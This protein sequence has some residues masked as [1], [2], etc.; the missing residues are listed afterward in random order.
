LSYDPSFEYPKG[1]GQELLRQASLW[2]GALDSDGRPRVSGG[3]LLEFRPTL[4][5][6]DTIVELWRGRPGSRR[7]EDDGGGGRTDEEIFNG[8][9]DDGDGFIDE[10]LGIIGQQMLIA[11]YTDD[12]PEA[13]AYV[14]GPEPH[15]PLGLSV[16]QEAYAWS[17]PGYQGIAG[18][19]YTITNHSGRTLSGVYLGLFAHLDSRSRNALAGHLNDAIH[20]V[21]FNR[22]FPKGITQVFVELPEPLVYSCATRVSR[23]VPAV[24]EPRGSATPD[25]PVVAVL[26]L[27]H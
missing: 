8:R 14:S 11:D 9:D 21:G 6:S 7:G 17:A 23:D 25:L 13:V 5:A 3:P 26:P 19:Q 22:A 12:Q 1:S 24:G 16:H 4:A 27:G 18:L 20:H 10:D 15:Q 2:V